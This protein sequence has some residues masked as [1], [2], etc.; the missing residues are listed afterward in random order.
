MGNLLNAKVSQTPLVVTAGQQDTR[1][2]IS[3]PLLYDDL[4][5]I[6]AP[7]VKWAE[8][9]SNAAQLPVLIRRA[10]HDANAAPGGPVFLALPMD[11]MDELCDV[12]IGEPSQID[13]RATGGSLPHLA[14]LLAGYQPGKVALIAGDE[15]YSSHASAETQQVAEPWARTFTVHPGLHASLFRHPTLCG[16]AICPPRRAASPGSCKTI[17][18]FLL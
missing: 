6:A 4:L 5:S 11:I 18:Q 2:A 13:R 1:H 15:I 7:A 17:R 16:V 3:D 14:K 9:V 8:N 12:A 10:F